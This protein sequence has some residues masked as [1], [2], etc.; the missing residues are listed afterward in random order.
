MATNAILKHVKD[1]GVVMITTS[2]VK[3]SAWSQQE[4][5]R[6]LV[7]GHRIP[8]C[9]QVGVPAATAMLDVVSKSIT[10]SFTAFRV[11]L[12]NQVALSWRSL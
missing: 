5:D 3:A 8:L 9:D 11:H 2:P 6:I 1:S 7:D 12:V 10:P 4:V